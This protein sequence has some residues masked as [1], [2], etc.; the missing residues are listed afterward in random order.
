MTAASSSRNQGEFESLEQRC[1]QYEGIIQ[2]VQV[3][4]GR[5]KQEAR[6]GME[7][8]EGMFRERMRMFVNEKEELKV[9]VRIETGQ[10]LSNFAF[11][12][13]CVYVFLELVV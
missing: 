10:G 7:F 3:E 5:S 9:E 1:K 13:T 8:G 11:R 2:A 6:K 12:L 4:L